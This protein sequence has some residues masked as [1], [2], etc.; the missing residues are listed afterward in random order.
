MPADVF[1]ALLDIDQAL[2]RSGVPPISPYWRAEAER[3][4]GSRA[5]LLVECVGRGGDKSRTSTK[6]AIAE[7]LAGDFHIPA[8]ERHYYTHVAENRDESAKT[9]SILEQYLRVL[10]V[11]YGRSGD[12]IELGG[13]ARGFRVLACRVGAVS[14]WRCIGWTADECAKWDN[15]GADPSQEVISS[16]RAMTVTHPGARGRMFSSP[17]GT[18]GYFHKV[19]SRGTN[20]EQIAG[21]AASWQANPSITE[22]HTHELEPIEDV[23]RREYAAVPMEGSEESLIAP[24]LVDRAT[25]SPSGGPDGGLDVARETGV[26]YVAGMDPAFARNAWAFVV[27]CQRRVAGRVKRSVVFAREWRGTRS[28]PLNPEWVLGQIKLHCRAYGVTGVWTDQ[29]EKYGLQALAGRPEIDLG[30]WPDE[31][32]QHERLER[33]DWLLRMLLEGEIELHPEKK[34]RDD[35]LSVRR[36]LTPSGFTVSLPETSDG[37]HAD[38][39]PALLLALSH[40]EVEPDAEPLEEGSPEAWEEAKARLIAGMEASVRRRADVEEWGEP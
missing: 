14:G 30:V 10:R 24:V 33:W 20:A 6:M 8:G 37:R 22:A 32:N 38:Y 15:E 3:F 29:Y 4:Y 5:R 21:H 40:A 19:W 12:T 25:R 28:A 23:W 11:Q 36:K 9:L 35:L 7:T 31:L 16:I 13:L 26:T 18:I 1:A 2:E 34:I 39:A 27:A 17:L